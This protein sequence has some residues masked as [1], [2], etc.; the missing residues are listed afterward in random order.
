MEVACRNGVGEAEDLRLPENIPYMMA[1]HSRRKGAVEWLTMD[2]WP[3]VELGAGGHR[4][5]PYSHAM[6]TEE[7]C[8]VEDSSMSRS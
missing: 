3:T 6:L 4:R 7:Y 1:A 5:A 8:V 2:R